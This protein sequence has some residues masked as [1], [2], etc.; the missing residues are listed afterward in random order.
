[1]AT[2]CD[3]CSL[4]APSMSCGGTIARA[5]KTNNGQKCKNSGNFARL[6][7]EWNCLLY[8]SPSPRDRG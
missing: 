7:H 1:M 6:R 2:V 4:S 3:Y 5:L 8:T